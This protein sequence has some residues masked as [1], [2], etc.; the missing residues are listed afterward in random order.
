MATPFSLSDFDYAHRGL[1]SKDDVPENSIAAYDAAIAAGIAMEFDIR[2]SKD[3]V[4]VCFHDRTLEKMT[5]RPGDLADFTAAELATFKLA[6]TQETIPTLEAVLARWPHHMPLIVEI[7]AMDIP[8]VPVAQA[9]A[10]QVE[11]YE[12]RAAIISFNKEAVA[13]IP[14]T[15]PRGLLIEKIYKSS[16]AEFDASLEDALSLQVDLLAIWRDDIE[17][18]APFAIQHGLGLVVWTVQSA[19]SSQAVA[20][21]AD[22]Q[23]FESF[24][25]ELV[26]PSRINR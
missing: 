12:G 20:P 10:K 7:K 4:P 21:Y 17:R 19:A 23:I 26:A 11:A 22:A 1:W 3:G 18:A 5:G 13:A 14:Q 25:P 2:L 8:P 15:I 9:T 6:N 16:T 24:A